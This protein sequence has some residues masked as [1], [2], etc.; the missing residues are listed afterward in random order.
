MFNIRKALAEL[1]GKESVT[2]DDLRKELDELKI[3]NKLEELTREGHI[4]ADATTQQ[5]ARA[6]IKGEATP[7]MLE[8][9]LR[10]EKPVPAQTKTVIPPAG[11]AAGI[12]PTEAAIQ[13]EMQRSGTPYHE[14]AAVVSTGG[15]LT[16]NPTMNT[17]HGGNA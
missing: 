6:A 13:T 3:D 4:N 10:A 7:A 14:A 8:Q 12:D 9:L 11:P 16:T 2:D 1:M 15:Q 17:A 5:L